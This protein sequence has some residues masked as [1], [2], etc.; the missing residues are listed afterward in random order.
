MRHSRGCTG[1]AW[2]TLR[3]PAHV[4]PS[5]VCACLHCV[6]AQLPSMSV[7]SPL[8][9]LQALSLSLNRL[10]TL[11]EWDTSTAAAFQVSAVRTWI[12]RTVAH[13]ASS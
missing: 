7:L 2:C 8:T 11:G 3:L 9:A 5:L 6:C 1:H 12:V 4:V 13:R 10:T